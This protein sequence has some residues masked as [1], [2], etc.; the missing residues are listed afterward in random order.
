MGV[1]ATQLNIPAS[2]LSESQIQ[3]LANND[4]YTHEFVSKLPAMDTDAREAIKHHLDAKEPKTLWQKVKKLAKSYA[5]IIDSREALQRAALEL[6]AFDVPALLAASTRNWLNFVETAFESFCG[7]FMFSMAPTITATVAK[8]IGKFMLPKEDHHMIDHLLKFQMPELNNDEAAMKGAQRIMDEE[9]SDQERVAQLYDEVGNDSKAQRYRQEADRIRNFAK[10]F[11]SSEEIREKA[12]SLKRAVIMAESMIEGGWWGGFGLVLR[13][14]RKYILG[15]KRFTGTKAYLN[16]KDSKK[17]GEGGEMSMFQKA[18]GAVMMGISPLTN[19]VLLKL[20]KG[21]SKDQLGGFLKIAQKHIDMVH[22]VFPNLGLM[23][24]Y[25][26]FPKW[27]GLIITA[28]GWYERLE[29]ILKV[30]TLVPS[31]WLGHQLTNGWLANAE[32]K[33]LAKQYGRSRGILVEPESINS[34]LKEPA[35]IH[36]V[37][38]KTKDSPVLQKKAT[39]KHASI[40]YKGFAMHSALVWAAMMIVN[41]ITKLNVLTDLKKKK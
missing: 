6:I 32:D 31:W 10:N 12:Y 17:L 37:M 19:W 13:A 28:Q 40:L 33:K 8:I 14:F 29:R 11:K 20:T 16:D 18:V 2:D 26:T 5:K 21:K 7:F 38:S 25:T 27:L 39:D 35:R 9:A 24:S 36:H 22:G 30:A 34:I 41:Y 4:I 1:S 15:A 23:F 3:P